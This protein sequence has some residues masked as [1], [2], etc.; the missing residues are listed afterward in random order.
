MTSFADDDAR[1]AALANEH[2][3][4]C[5]VYDLAT[6][7]SDYE[8]LRA[9]LPARVTIAYAVK[10]NPHAALLRTFADLGASFDCASSGEL[11]RVE[12]LASGRLFF[13]GPGKHTAELKHALD[14]RARIQAEG[15]E[16][17]ERVEQLA[18]SRIAVNLRV[19]PL[20]AIEESTRI[21]GGNGP[22]AFGVDEEDLPELAR[23]AARLR[24]VRIA[25]L[26]VFAASN[27][28]TADRLAANHAAVFALA[29]R[30]VKEFH[31]DLEQIDLGGG[32]GVAYA[33]GVAELDVVAVGENLERL[34]AEHDW[35]QGRVIV[36]PGRYLAARCGVYLTRVV[37]TKFSRGTRFTILE[38]GVNHLLR[39]LLV[40][41]P[42]PVRAIGVDGASSPTTLA[43]P[44]C[45]SLDRLGDVDLPALDPGAL[46]AFLRTGAY[47]ATE[48]MTKFLSHPEAK[49]IAV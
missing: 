37:R 46:L 43:G 25:G 26:H 31:F 49:E 27:E 10:A 36:E 48:A 1:L 6:A 20:A 40:G 30:M 44:L 47:G 7:R 15:F 23:R 28:L 32:L 33:P 21:L 38:A 29:R 22:S 24:R 8:R 17:L 19:H 16:D 14:L 45:T 35:F 9:A 12:S 34:L 39:P 13:T 11:T 41:Q 5:F 42:F 3:T 18:P 4:P 2:G